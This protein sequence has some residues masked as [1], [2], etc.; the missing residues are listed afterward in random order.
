MGSTGTVLWLL[1]LMN[2]V[3]IKPHFITAP[4]ALYSAIPPLDPSPPN[5]IPNSEKMM[6]L[7]SFPTAHVC[8]TQEIP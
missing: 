7:L 5:T 4:G 1:L 2:Q 6:F 3:S 8:Y